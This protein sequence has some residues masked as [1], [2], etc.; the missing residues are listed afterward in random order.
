[1]SHFNITK[2]PAKKND[3]DTLRIKG[4]KIFFSLNSY[5]GK[6]GEFII[7]YIPSLNISGYGKTTEEAEEFLK[8]EIQVFCEDVMKMPS[9]EKDAFL[10][11]LGFEKEK[12]RSKNFSKAYVDE[13]GILQEFEEGTLKRTILQMTA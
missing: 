6:Q 13:N 5:S 2:R 4:G 11:S 8:T 10:E 7:F 1:M 3:R 9:K 12:F